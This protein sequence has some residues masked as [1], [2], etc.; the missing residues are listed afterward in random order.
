M[1]R[2]KS[3]L[4]F[5]ALMIIILIGGYFLFFKTDKI[6]ASRVILKDNNIYLINDVLG[7]KQLTAGNNFKLLFD[8][9][10]GKILFGENWNNETIESERRGGTRLW[11]MNE[12]ASNKIEISDELVNNAFLGK[13]KIF[14]TTLNLDLYIADLNGADKI[15]IQEKA[16][17]PDLSADGQFLV[18]QKLNPDWRPGDY[19]DKALGLAI[20]NLTTGKEQLLTDNGEDFNPFWF[21]NG[22]N[23]LFF[24][25]SKEGLA[26]HFMINPDGTNRKQLTN[27]GEKFVSNSTVDIPSEKPAWS[28]NGKY[29]VYESDKEIWINEFDLNNNIKAK[30][31]AYGKNPQWLSNDNLSIISTINQ[32]NT[33]LNIDLNGNIIK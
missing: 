31:I 28:P 30:Q 21:P 17:N 29:L 16:L 33:L 4:T 26:S 14:Y 10:N 8:N 9:K 20:L 25:R 2:K 24:S 22:Q 27:S 13:N 5:S 32:E 12:D 18:Y 11:I 3:L 7:E 1:T 6:N 19:Y 15:K 23:I